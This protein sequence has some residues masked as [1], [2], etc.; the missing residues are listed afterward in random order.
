MFAT[1]VVGGPCQTPEDNVSKDGV[2]DA[3]LVRS[4]LGSGIVL[5]RGALGQAIRLAIGVGEARLEDGRE[6]SVAAQD[7]VDGA[8]HCCGSCRTP[9]RGANSGSYQCPIQSGQDSNEKQYAGSHKELCTA[10]THTTRSD[11]VWLVI[12]RLSSPRST[13]E[14]GSCAE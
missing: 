6:R 12:A 13:V 7:V 2:H 14:E 5:M 9:R 8:E 11:G 1:A 3:L 10:C 4:T